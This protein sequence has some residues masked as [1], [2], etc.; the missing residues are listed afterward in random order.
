MDLNMM[1]REQARSG[2]Q[3]QLDAAVT[4]GDTAQA[5]KL[6]DDIAK[7]DVATAPKPAV[8]YGD[9]EIRAE[10]NKLDWFGT[11]PKKSAKAVEFGKTMDPKK[12][13]TA[14]AFAA[15]IV[16]AVDEEFK[17]AGSTAPKE[18]DEEDPDGGEGEGKPAPKKRA[19][20]GP[21]ENDRGPGTGRRTSS[22]PWA[23]LSD[24]PADIQKEIKRQADKFVPANAKKET[25]DGYIS[26]ALE[27]HYREHQRK[28][29]K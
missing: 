10:L 2:L 21:G 22:G 9:A 18:E 14:E 17:P 20:D 12:F 4:N 25:R 26:K 28:G 29:K 16:K 13:A 3:T 11:D 6:A 19:T 23:K 1:M 5:R 24:A 27:S 15:A 8:G 7:L